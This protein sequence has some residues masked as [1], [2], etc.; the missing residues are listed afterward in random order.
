MAK[1]KKCSNCGV[2]NEQDSKFCEKCGNKLYM[3]KEIKNKSSIVNKINCPFCGS[4]IP[5]SVKKCS[6]C[7][8]WIKTHDRGNNFP[9]ILGYAS[10][11]IAFIL[12][13]IL[14]MGSSNPT[15][16]LLGFAIPFILPLII[17]LYL[18][19]RKDPKTRKHGIILLIIW[20][21]LVMFFYWMY[22]SDLESYL[23][24]QEARRNAYNNYYYY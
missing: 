5:A 12:S 13:I 1:I 20:I 4:E 11:L 18:I 15:E 8:E 9:I 10:I 3:E 6:N 2:F 17:T 22:Q 7:G 16:A 24:L 23:K 21:I 14:Y 19:T